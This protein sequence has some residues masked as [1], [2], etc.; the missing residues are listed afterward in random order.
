MLEVDMY[1]VAD[2]DFFGAEV[3]ANENAVLVE[4]SGKR[5][6][7]FSLLSFSWVIPCNF[8]TSRCI[9]ALSATTSKTRPTTS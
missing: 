2:N 7:S 8:R 1:L 5:E 6:S 4:I 3:G 9:I